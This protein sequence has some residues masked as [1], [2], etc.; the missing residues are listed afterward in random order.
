MDD[1]TSTDGQETNIPTSNRVEREGLKSL[2]KRKYDESYLSLGF[3]PI[4]NT[5][6]PDGQ[7]VICK[8]NPPEQ[9]LGTR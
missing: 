2:K 8:K 1:N 7:C 6:H 4:G 5:E 9:F 3:I